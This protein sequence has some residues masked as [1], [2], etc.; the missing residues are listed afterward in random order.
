M[1]ANFFNMFPDSQIAKKYG[2]GRTKT[3]NIIDTLAKHDA[4][5]LINKL[6][7]APFSIATDGSNDNEATKLY[8]VAV[9]V[10]DETV[11]KITSCILS[12]KECKEA[13]T[14]ENIFKILDSELKSAQILWSN[15]VSFSTDNASVMLGTS[16][17]VAAY[18]HKENATVYIMGCPCHLMHLAA[19]KACKALPV[20]I[21]ELLIDIYYYIDKSSNRLQNIKKFQALCD[22][23]MHKILKHAPTRWLSLAQCSFR[24]VT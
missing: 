17:G 3:S 12:I 1:L 13:S 6:R 22:T 9:R 18:I 20:L 5:A 4:E 14:G 8:P 11:C 19:K 15:C 24:Q 10:F 2:S 21:D 16:K 7:N 23:E